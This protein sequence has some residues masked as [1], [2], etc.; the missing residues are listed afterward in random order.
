MRGYPQFS[1]WIS[2][3]LV[4]IYISFI[5]INQGK[6][7]FELVGTVL[8]LIFVLLCYFF[9]EVATIVDNTLK[10]LP[11]QALLVASKQFDPTPQ[12]QCCFQGVTISF[13]VMN[14]FQ[15]YIG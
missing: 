11:L 9:E 5:I 7:T 4:K 14:T 13:L 15:I 2:I 3:T 6:N 1:L 8:K 10:K 12:F